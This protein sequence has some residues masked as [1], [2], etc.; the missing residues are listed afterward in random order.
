MVGARGPNSSAGSPPG[1]CDGSW[2]TEVEIEDSSRCSVMVV[3]LHNFSV[4][5]RQ[6]PGE[7]RRL[8]RR[9]GQLEPERAAAARLGF[10]ADLA[11]VRRNQPLD[12]GQSQPGAWLALGRWSSDE[13][14]E[15]HRTR[16]GGKSWP[17]VGYLH[18]KLTPL[19]LRSDRDRAHGRI[20][21]VLDRVA[22]EVVDQADQDPGSTEDEAWLPGRID[23]QVD[24]VLA[25]QRLKLVRE[26]IEDLAHRRRCVIRRGSRL[27]EV[28]QVVDH[29]ARARQPA[30]RPA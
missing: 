4:W 7:I 30:M 20:G 9:S 19:E 22:R 26:A 29:P 27:G 13:W 17:A 8:A 14:L 2:R 10:N 11:A 5:G 18:P 12:G 15:N 16:F 3:R 6:C 24:S 23:S 1:C 21:G 25:R 28:E